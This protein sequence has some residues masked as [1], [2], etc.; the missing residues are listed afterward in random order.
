MMRQGGFQA[1]VARAV[2][3]LGQLQGMDPAIPVGQTVEP[4]ANAPDL[5]SGDG[6]LEQGVQAG[7]AAPN[8]E[9][10]LISGEDASSRPLEGNLRDGLHMR[11]AV[12]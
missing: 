4:R 5:A 9:S 2:D 10:G 3:A 12:T 11:Q 7:T 8:P 6:P 1:D